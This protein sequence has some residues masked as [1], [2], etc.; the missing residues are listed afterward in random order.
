MSEPEPPTDAVL[1]AV[2][3]L[4]GAD[5]RVCTCD[6]EFDPA[7]LE[8]W[9]AGAEDEEVVAH[10]GICAACRSF[11]AAL[12][13]LAP[14]V[15]AR[16]EGAGARPGSRKPL[17]WFMIPALAAAAAL[18][19]ALWPSGASLPAYRGE[20]PSGGVQVVKAT[21][22]ASCSWRAGMPEVDYERGSRSAAS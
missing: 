18:V 1:Q 17:F 15:V 7:R 9:K 21:P 13:P 4:E 10:L 22:Q 16:I 3:G 8:A 5:A 2:A 11:V 19:V 12:A 6:P 14:G 20:A